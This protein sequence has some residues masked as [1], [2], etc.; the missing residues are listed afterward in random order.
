MR[1]VRSW[2][3]RRLMCDSRV[4][5]V[6]RASSSEAMGTEHIERA[7]QRQSG[8][9]ISPLGR[10]SRS[11]FSGSLSVTTPT[12]SES[13]HPTVTDSFQRLPSSSAMRFLSTLNRPSRSLRSPL[14]SPPFPQ[15]H[16]SRPSSPSH[17][18]HWA[19]RSTRDDADRRAANEVRYA[20]RRSRTV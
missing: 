10:F 5:K 18:F 7:K 4:D 3:V 19:T 12:P 11:L 20:C 6:E 2:V 16:S 15:L 13:L 14:L 8:G 17:I 9:V 1:V